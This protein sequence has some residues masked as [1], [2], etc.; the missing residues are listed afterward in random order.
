LIKGLKEIELAF[1]RS[2]H[3]PTTHTNRKPTNNTSGIRNEQ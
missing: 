2:I 3:V 1:Q